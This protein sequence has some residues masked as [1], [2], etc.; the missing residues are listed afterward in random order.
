MPVI[1]V[2]HKVVVAIHNEQMAEHGGG[3]GLRDGGLLQSALFRPLNRAHYDDKNIPVLA[4]SYG[5]GL[6]N[7]HPFVDGNKRTAL[8]VAELFLTLNGYQLNASDEACFD[9]FMDLAKGTLSEQHF[10]GWLEINS[11]K[12]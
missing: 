7:N 4:A 9:T 1:W 11:E 12:S 8:V 3:S 10:S 2:D 6:I 5:Y